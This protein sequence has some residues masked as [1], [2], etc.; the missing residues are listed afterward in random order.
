MNEKQDASHNQQRNISTIFYL[1]EYQQF[2]DILLSFYLL[3]Y[4]LYLSFYMYNFF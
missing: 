4:N 3:F 1:F 2:Y